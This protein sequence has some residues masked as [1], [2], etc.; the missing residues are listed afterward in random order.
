M[1]FFE[2]VFPR[3]ANNDYKGSPIAFYGFLLVVATQSFSGLVHYFTYD[4]GKVQIAGLMPLQGTPDPSG[5]IFALSANAGAW[6]LIIL[7]IYG[8]V[9]WR[10]RSLIPLMFVLAIAKSLLGFGNTFLHP[11]DPAYF[12]HTPPALIARVPR[13]VFELVMLFLAVRRPSKNAVMADNS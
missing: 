9:L 11:L 4:S 6:E 10:Y 5:L 3:Q 8:V 13:S 1:N 12:E 7:A 2:T